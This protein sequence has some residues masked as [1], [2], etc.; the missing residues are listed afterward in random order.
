MIQRVVGSDTLRFA[1]PHVTTETLP[2][3]G[4]ILRSAIPLGATP[5]C[6]GDLLRGW[7]TS[8]PDRV[9]LAERDA[10][11]SWRR[12]TYAAVAATVRCI[13][14]ALLD[15]GL[16]PELPVLI[17]S[18][19]SIDHALM[20]LGAMQIGV[21][22]APVS[23]AYSRRSRDFVKLRAVRDQVRPGL[24]FVDDGAA[25]AAALDAIGLEEAELVVVG[26]PHPRLGGTPFAALTATVPTPQL[27]AAEAA[28]GPETI[29]K[30][31]FTSG[32]TGDPKGVVNTQRMLCSN[33]ESWALGWPFL[34]DRPPVLVDWLPWSHT[35]GGNATFN[36]ALRNGGSFTIDAGKPA[37]GLIDRTVA[38]LREVSPTVYFNVP[39]GYAMLLDHLERDA[40]LAESFFRDLDVLFYAA[41]SLP[42]SVWDRLDAVARRTVGRSVPMISAWGTTETAPMATLVHFAMDRPGNIGV[43]APGTEIKLVPADDK[44][45]IRVRGPNVTPGYWRRPDLTRALFDEDGFYR[46]GDAVRLADPDDPQSGIVFDGRL[47]ENFKLTSGTWVSV[48]ALRVAAIAGCDPVVEDAVV[49]GHDRDEIGL[50]VFPSL[51][52]CRSLCPHLAD[53]P[54]ARLIAEPAVRR[55]LAAGLARHN[56]GAGGSSRR[57]ARAI[58]LAEPPSIDRG[59][60]TDKGYL[61]Q[62]AVLGSRR[63]TVERLHDRGE[64]AEIV[65]PA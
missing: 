53:A 44:I 60:I 35:F 41:A 37:P 18:E 25:H 4:M 9:F 36:L 47:S 20:T 54:L 10:V 5:R 61:N 31:L 65:L 43:P 22:V 38:T 55:A 59:E 63:K 27:A 52:G 6:L 11:G 64:W 21:P 15:R 39:G 2:D 16:G 49:T 23:T 34:T 30:I 26:A 8:A 14:Q 28:V 7:A 42:Q 32:S 51:A 56:E 58:F 1:T 19:N 33:Q 12:M 50:L 62:R 57:I 17:L 13:A 48:G 46:P 45:E 29:A 40:A 3:G 24:V